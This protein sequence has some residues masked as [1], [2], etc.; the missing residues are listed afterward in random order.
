MT[1][2]QKTMTYVLAD[3]LLKTGATFGYSKSQLE[4]LEQSMKQYL[5]DCQKCNR[6]ASNDAA[7]HSTAT[8]KLNRNMPYNKGSIYPWRNYDWDY[9]NF[10]NN[11]Y[12]TLATGATKSG[13]I[14]AMVKNL[15]AMR[16]LVGAYIQDP[17]PSSSSIA[18]GNRQID[19]YPYYECTDNVFDLNGQL[20]ASP[21]DTRRCRIR[22]E[23]KYG[24]KE[25]APFED[26]IFKDP[27]RIRGERSS[28]YYVR[29]GSCP[30]PDIKTEEECVKRGY[31]WTA[32]TI[33]KLF[34]SSAGAC[35]QPRYAYIDN[36]PGYK[37]GGARLQGLVPSI[38][39]DFLAL[40]PDKIINVALGNSVENN[41]ELQQCPEISDEPP[42]PIPVPTAPNENTSKA[43]SFL[44]KLN[45]LAK[46]TSTE[47]F[48]NKCWMDSI[49]FNTATGMAILVIILL[50]LIR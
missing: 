16:K 6:E 17:N 21:G 42:K 29:I 1:N 11:Q 45:P 38:A 28:S 46:T 30:R 5:I 2:C 19:D 10:I 23:I 18:G 4:N 50:L 48:K 35:S 47:G 33:E 12:S 26:D 44:S 14:S 32:S 7:C 40:T 9:S 36:A 41:F 20:L 49:D 22:H 15:G 3:S 27:D 8:E 34:D 24:D 37:I 43:Q 39:K 31:T 13:S 25:K